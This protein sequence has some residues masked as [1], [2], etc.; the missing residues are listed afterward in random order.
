MNSGTVR[1]VSLLDEPPPPTS[2]HARGSR[3]PA[4]LSGPTPIAVGPVS[5][6]TQP[7]EIVHQAFA[8]GD[9][10]AL[11]EAYDRWGALVHSLALRSLGNPAD[12]GDA[13]QA[14]FVSAW[15]SRGRYD[16][17]RPLAAWLTR[18][19]QR[20]VVDMHRSRARHPEP[21]EQLPETV[22]DEQAIEQAATRM[23]LADALAELPRERREVIH[24]AIVEQHT[25][26]EVAARTG[27]PVGTV[28]SHIRRG[29]KVLRDR[30]AVDA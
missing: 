8:A 29:L 10:R 22:A 30:L 27:L 20:R 26:A 28:K 2:R 6:T 12:A 3:A 19:A 25:H 11:K 15:R 18:I 1:G 5:L 16:P 14:V 24:L 23:L 21:V 9:D 13:T 7:D 17:S 4:T